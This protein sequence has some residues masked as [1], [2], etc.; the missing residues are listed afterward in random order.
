MM[1]SVNDETNMSSSAPSTPS[2][3]ISQLDAAD[4]CP[5]APLRLGRAM[6]SFEDESG[7]CST[8]PRVLIPSVDDHKGHGIL[9]GD[10]IKP[11]PGL[12]LRERETHI[13]SEL[14]RWLEGR[15]QVHAR[16]VGLASY[17]DDEIRDT[18]S[19]GRWPAARLHMLVG[20]LPH[21]REPEL[22]YHEK[23]LWAAIVCM[24]Y[25]LNGE[26]PADSAE[27]LAIGFVTE[28]QLGD[29][30]T[31]ADYW[32]APS[33]FEPLREAQPLSLEERIEG[34]LGFWDIPLKLELP[35]WV[36]TALTLWVV[37]YAWLVAM[38]VSSR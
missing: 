5:P 35:I 25:L 12:T 31:I 22:V 30:S 21:G 20:D 28:D 7:S 11:D 34:A 10:F 17:D 14:N 36:W 18:V 19:L 29:G 15:I 32:D 24:K 33:T 16:A 3:R 1:S 38:L 4:R 23:A 8:V 2:P 27:E 6:S 37:L 9:A 13:L 26:A